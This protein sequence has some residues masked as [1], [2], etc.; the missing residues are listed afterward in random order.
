MLMYFITTNRVGIGMQP[1]YELHLELQNK[2]DLRKTRKLVSFRSLYLDSKRQDYSSL[3]VK[4]ESI[5]HYWGSVF[6]FISIIVITICNMENMY[7]AVHA[8]VSNG[9]ILNIELLRLGTLMSLLIYSERI[10]SRGI[11]LSELSDEL[12]EEAKLS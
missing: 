5:Y 6:L 10:R 2:S 9:N 8:L 3:Q 11:L 4:Q 1:Q 12:A 7:P